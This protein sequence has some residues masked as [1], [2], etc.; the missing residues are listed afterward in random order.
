MWAPTFLRERARFLMES[1]LTWTFSGPS[2]GS[3]QA[4][5]AT[6]TG[7]RVW[8]RS[9]PGPRDR[10]LFLVMPYANGRPGRHYRRHV[11]EPDQY[12]QG[13]WLQLF[14]TRTGYDF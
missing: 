4:I 1:I 11:T 6:P 13:R 3:A 14:E 12:V 10:F 2:L 7:A 9:P 5:T 8:A